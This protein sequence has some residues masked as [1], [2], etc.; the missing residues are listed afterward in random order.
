MLYGISYISYTHISIDEYMDRQ[1]D[2]LCYV[3]EQEFDFRV[4]VEASDIEK[5]EGFRII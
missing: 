1:K 4:L 3:Q 2:M 5:E